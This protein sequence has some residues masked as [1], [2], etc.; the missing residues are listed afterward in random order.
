[1]V[2]GA[3]AIASLPLMLS[4]APEVAIEVPALV[5]FAAY[6]AL[7]FLRLRRLTAAYLKQHADVADAP[8]FIILTVTA[9]AIVAA[10]GSLFLALNSHGS[11]NPVELLLAFASVVFG[12]IT[13]HTMAAMHYAHVYWRPNRRKPTVHRGGLEFPET[14]EPCGHDFLY[15][16]LVIGMTAQTS[17]VVITSTSMRKLNLVHATVSYFFNTVLVAAAVNAAVSLAG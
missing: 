11:S 8:T 7:A 1:M 15:F 10:I 4:Y 12:W 17:D 3:L 5:F 14:P 13:I 6:L 16:S 2:A 9:L